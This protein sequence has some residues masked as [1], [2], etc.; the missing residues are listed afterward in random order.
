MGKHE[1][2]EQG[3]TSATQWAELMAQLFDKL[4]GKEAEVSYGFRNLEIDIPKAAGPQGQTL[5]SAK[6]V[7]NGE[8]VI[9]AQAR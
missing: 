6:W 2:E 9:K 5:G 7:V 4:T 8:I 3:R 1:T